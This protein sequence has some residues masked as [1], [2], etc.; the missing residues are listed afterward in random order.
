MLEDPTHAGGIAFRIAGS[1][2]GVESEANAEKAPDGPVRDSVA[3]EIEESPGRE[4]GGDGCGFRGGG[5]REGEGGTGGCEPG[6]L[7]CVSGEDRKAGDDFSLR[8]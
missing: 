7:E 6:D 8:R 5:F 2:D 4:H 3:E 1:S